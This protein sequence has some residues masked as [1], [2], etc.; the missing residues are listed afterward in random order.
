MAEAAEFCLTVL[1]LSEVCMAVS[2]ILGLKACT[3]MPGSK[4]F[5]AI[6]SQNMDQ[7]PVWSISGL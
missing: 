3:T 7:K 5:M 6:I 1:D 4:F 2:W